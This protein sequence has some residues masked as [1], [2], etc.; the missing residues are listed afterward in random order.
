MFLPELDEM[1]K[2]RNEVSHSDL[3][4]HRTGFCTVLY[5]VKEMDHTSEG[6]Q[7]KNI[8]NKQPESRKHSLWP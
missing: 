4:A 6:K 5:C 7:A 3:I 2:W 8:L 1:K